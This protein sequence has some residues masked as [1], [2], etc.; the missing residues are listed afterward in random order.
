MAIETDGGAV[1]WLQ[2]LFHRRPVPRFAEDARPAAAMAGYCFRNPALREAALTTR[3][4]RSEHTG[5][6][7]DNQR[8]EFLG[9]AVLELVS[10]RRLY[11]RF[12]T[13]QE[14]AL[15]VMR[16]RITDEPAL[17]VVARRLGLGPL[18]RMGVGS[19]QQGGRDNDST[20]ADAVE[21]LLGAIYLDGGLPA[22]EAAFD[23]TFGPELDAL[24]GFPFSETARWTRNP[25]GHL[26][27]VAAKRYGTEPVYTVL[28]REG[29]D[30]A[31]VFRVEVR[32][33]GEGSAVGEGPSKQKA[34]AAAAAALLEQL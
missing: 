32:V 22:A 14:G 29:P 9:D 34:E 27:Q 19:D 1:G 3:S 24:S 12:P 20:L 15:S 6:A 8:L 21:S 5:V 17:A 30:H 31:P 10:S 4:Y 2:T 18:L 26:Q 11:E 13:A 16:S 33:G 7:D 23:G 28:S 25:K